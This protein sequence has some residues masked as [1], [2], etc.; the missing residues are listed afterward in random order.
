MVRALRWFSSAIK[1]ISE[2]TWVNDEL[3][4]SLKYAFC[5]RFLNSFDFVSM[6]I[7]AVFF[8]HRSLLIQISY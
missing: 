1:I 6:G 7:Y 4:K 3:D 5:S 8:T 2:E